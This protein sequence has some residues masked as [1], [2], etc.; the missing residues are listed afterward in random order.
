MYVRLQRPGRE[1]LLRNGRNPAGFGTAFV[2]TRVPT[3]ISSTRCMACG[4][5]GG[6]FWVVLP[7]NNLGRLLIIKASSRKRHKTESLN[8]LESECVEGLIEVDQTLL[9]LMIR[10]GTADSDH[11][12]NF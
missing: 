3:P 1:D 7:K 5:I 8:G 12:L 10:D 2:L 11:I 9:N 4:E 6:L